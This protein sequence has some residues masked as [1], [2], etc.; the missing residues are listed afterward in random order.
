MWQILGY[1]ACEN[2]LST[3]FSLC[4][5]LKEELPFLEFSITCIKLLTIH[6]CVCA[7]MWTKYILSGE[8]SFLFQFSHQP[9]E[10]CLDNRL[11]DLAL[12]FDGV[13]FFYIVRILFHQ[14]YIC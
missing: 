12:F 11:N 5:Q 14:W 7:C 4:L 10:M 13:V 2:G 9:I 6:E 8:G 3:L 1:M